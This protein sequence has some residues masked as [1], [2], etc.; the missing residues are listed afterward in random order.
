MPR[1]TARLAPLLLLLLHAALLPSLH[2]VEAKTYRVVLLPGLVEVRAQLGL[3]TAPTVASVESIA[4]NVTAAIAWC[5]NTPVLARP[6]GDRV[7]VM[8]PCNAVALVYWA[9]PEQL[10]G[11]WRLTLH[12]ANQ[13]RL[14]VVLSRGLT[15]TYLD[16]PPVD[17]WEG[18]E[19][20]VMAFE[21]PANVTIAYTLAEGAVPLSNVTLTVPIYTT[22]TRTHTETVGYLEYW[23]PILAGQIQS[24]D[25]VESPVKGLSMLR[26]ILLALGVAA[27]A[28]AGAYVLLRR[29]RGGFEF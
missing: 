6:A 24:L 14:E 18:G 11:S 16:T 12:A 3:G 7:I 15:L 22:E 9:Q 4:G 5:G 28:G 8:A 27:A 20:V 10:D 13:T 17:L 19:G 26:L 29:R 21:G 1:A 2:A 25:Q 23:V